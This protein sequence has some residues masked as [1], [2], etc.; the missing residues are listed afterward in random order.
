[1][2]LST[3]VEAGSLTLFGYL[4][5]PLLYIH[6]DTNS[7]GLLCISIYFWYFFIIHSI[8]IVLINMHNCNSLVFPGLVFGF[9]LNY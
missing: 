5:R 7:S 9:L 2:E 3:L 6:T 4:L 1:M 8:V